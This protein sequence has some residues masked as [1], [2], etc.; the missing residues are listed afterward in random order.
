MDLV[1]EKV[2]YLL[3]AKVVGSLEGQGGKSIEE[4]KG[5]PIPVRIQGDLDNPSPMIDVEA[6]AKALAEAKLEE[7]K[8]ELLEKAGSKIEKK[9]GV[10]LFK[11]FFGQ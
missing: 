7:K 4:L 5:I 3:T 6:L 8:G 11:G 10:D 9:L 1:R 2:D